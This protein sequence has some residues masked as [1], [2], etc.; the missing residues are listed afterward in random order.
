[1]KRRRHT[2][3][4]RFYGD[5]KPI[6]LSAVSAAQAEIIAKAVAKKNGW[7]FESVGIVV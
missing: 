6:R 5:V 2:Y 3:R 4:A 1:M 7:K